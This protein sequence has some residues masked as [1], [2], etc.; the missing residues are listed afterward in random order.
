[1]I[2]INKT[3]LT[4]SIIILAL[5]ITFTL[6]SN[7]Q[8]Y[9]EFT[10]IDNGALNLPASTTNATFI[11][12]QIGTFDQSSTGNINGG[13]DWFASQLQNNAT[14]SIG[15]QLLSWWS[16]KNGRNTTLEVVNLDS[17]SAI[18]PLLHIQI[19]DE[20]CIEILNFCDTYTARDNHMYD[21]SNLFANS[22]SD[23]SESGLADKEGIVVITP[24]S[25][26]MIALPFHRAIAFSRLQG[27]VTI[28]D[29][30]NNFDYH[31]KM[32]A[33]GTDFLRDCTITNSNGFNILDGVGDC[34]FETFTPDNLVHTFSTLPG[35][36][37]SRSDLVVFSLA[38][39]YNLV[40]YNPI[41]FSS[42][43]SVGP[44]IFDENENAESCPFVNSCFSRLGINDA[45]PNS[46]LPISPVAASDFCD[47][48]DPDAIIGTPGDDILNGTSGNDIIIG[49]GGNDTINGLGGNDCIDGS[50]GNDIL[51][52]NAGNDL[53]AG[54]IGDD[55]IRGGSGEDN[56]WGNEGDDE[57]RGGT[58]NDIIRGN[59]GEDDIRGNAGDDTIRGGRENDDI[60]GGQGNDFIR[61]G[62]G[63]DNIRGNSGNDEILGNNG[64]DEIRGGSGDDFINGGNGSDIIRGGSDTDECINGEDVV[65]C[66]L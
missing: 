15:A 29:N 56:I 12:G 46:D 58:D 19:F 10:S 2:N 31:S 43:V 25:E 39:Q 61:G 48:T 17:N 57:I 11:G 45:L 62:R 3:I 21:L 22:G 9:C 41:P 55:I 66:E 36:I 33:R 38:D 65:Q 6:N 32:W 44:I 34:K 18:S 8:E 20:N 51:N 7:S 60:R 50:D 37:E 49:L 4:N 13:M 40:V 64:D 35:T 47:G 42:S 14:S 28:K 27:D 1:M 5:V 30:T 54:E 26:C 53:I 23:I 59:Q 16:R 63:Q 52:G 24:V